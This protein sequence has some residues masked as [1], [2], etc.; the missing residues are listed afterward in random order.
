M[1]QQPNILSFGVTSGNGEETLISVDD[2]D[3]TLRS[4]SDDRHGVLFDGRERN[5]KTLS[6]REMD[7]LTAIA[8]TLLPS[9][10]IDITASRDVSHL[11]LYRTSAS[12]IGTPHLCGE[13]MVSKLQHAM[14]G[15]LRL[16]LWLLGTWYGTVILC[17]TK[18]MSW[19][20][21]FF[22][23]LSQ[24]EPRRREEIL[25]SWSFSSFYLFRL[26]FKGM[27]FLILLIHF[28]QVNEKGQ[29]P[30]WDGIGYC[31]PDPDFICKAQEKPSLDE[32]EDDHPLRKALVDMEESPMDALAMAGITFSSAI[33]RTD[34]TTF[35][36][37]TPKTIRCDAVV[38]GSGS[39]GGVVAG[40][41]AKAG[42]K[43][44]VL[45][46]ADYHARSNLSL[47]EGDAMDR[48]YE[49]RGLLATDD[50]GVVVLAGSAVGG[51][52]AV[53]WS[54]SLRTPEHVMD[55]WCEE[56]E[57]ELFR[58]DA[59]ACALD[60]VCERMG[61][62]SGHVEGREGFNNEVLRRGCEELGY[63]VNDI[64]RNSPSDH[65]CG[66]CCFGCKDGKK[67]GTNETWLVDM[68][69]SGNGVLLPR[70]RALKVVVHEGRRRRRS[71]RGVVFEYGKNSNS[72]EVC[73]VESKVTVIACGALGTP[74]LLK[75]S[76][77]R[78]PNIGRNLHLH[79]VVMAWGYFP[80]N[81]MWPGRE[82]RSY[83]GGI[84]TAMST[85]VSNFK[86]NGY[87]AVIQTPML[88]PGMFSVVTPWLSGA[89]VKMRMERFSRT[90]HVFALARDR[91]SG[92]VNLPGS[93]TY[94]LEGEDE[95]SLQRGLEKTLR[96]LAAAGAEEIGTQH[97][98]GE[99]LNVKMASSHEFER[100]VRRESQRPLRDLR[101]P[102]CSA[103]QMGSCRMGV[104]PERSVVDERGMT[105]EVEGLFVADA[106]VL[107]TA[108]GVNPM[109]TV[110][111]IAHCTAQS[112]IES[113]RRK[114][115][116][117]N[118]L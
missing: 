11:A 54:A 109:V 1:E 98:K 92:V 18:S 61:V 21:P 24:L 31:G 55:E 35:S 78:N 17:G 97:C 104:D 29:N 5:A 64:P 3:L 51:G 86:T 99:R 62:H 41:L 15:M 6:S 33:H 70:C 59:Y 80:E 56:N 115:K 12:M 103:H 105:W 27:K 71:A 90:A 89:D 39:G 43:V 75:R 49:G 22:R 44:V 34:K 102:I 40:V 14:L 108:L 28:T 45:E 37:M 50:L 53:N 48:M 30:T 117:K 111:A 81:Y 36:P 19:R 23:R 107:P 118:G 106:S 67:K 76:G 4:N 2:V 16:A 94:E 100:F 47:L 25:L 38:V 101:T 84:M 83:E 113:L 112:V 20:F 87:G 7:S 66:W 77:L 69:E 52:S 63:P 46:K 88:H 96:I 116:K 58:S 72:K 42:Y 32:K 95:V 9:M 13:Y 26:L 82:K 85:V 65:Y 8:D 73:L 93:L 57:L 110:Q 68:A 114:T 10:S 91:G 74:G 79:P 60:A